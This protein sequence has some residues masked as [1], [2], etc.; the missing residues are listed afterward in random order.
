MTLSRRALAL[1]ALGAASL[2]AAPRLHASSR[3]DALTVLVPQPAGGVTDAFARALAPALARGLGRVAVVENLAGASGSIA[4]NRLLAAPADGTTVMVGSP[5]ETVLAPLTLNSVQYQPTD[6][7][8]LG[9]INDSPLALYARSGLPAQD[10]DGLI[11]LARQAGARPLNYGSTGQGSLF[12]LLIETLLAGAGVKAT[13]VPYRGGMPMLTDLQAGNIDFTLLPVDALLGQ[14]V[15]GGRIKVL[16]VSS[17]QRLPRFPAAATFDES[18]AAPRL[19]HPSIWVG[20]LVSAALSEGLS[21]RLHQALVEALADPRVLQ[22]I[23]AS[24]G[25]VPAPLSLQDAARRY[26]ADITKLHALAQAARV[27]RR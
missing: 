2:A 14:V 24:G 1:S 23:E 9:L 3:A 26:A 8:L 7:R 5:S 15:A 22:G 27:A 6:F 13:H 25:S 4:A 19:G 16:G 20:L 21:A 18:Q 10:L 12:H 11:A 17:A